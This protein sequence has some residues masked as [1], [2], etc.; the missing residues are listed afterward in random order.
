MLEINS[1]DASVECWRKSWRNTTQQ[2]RCRFHPLSTAFYTY[3]IV[4][5]APCICPHAPQVDGTVTLPIVANVSLL[6][7]KPIRPR[8]RVLLLQLH[9][10]FA[11]K[12]MCLKCQEAESCLA[13]RLTHQGKQTHT[14]EDTINREECEL[15]QLG[16]HHLVWYNQDTREAGH[17]TTTDLSVW[18]AYWDTL[19]R[20]PTPICPP[21]RP[22]PP[23]PGTGGGLPSFSDESAQSPVRGQW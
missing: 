15:T 14:A 10:R 7:C 4:P 12:L 17:G 19:Y 13:I 16:H 18:A 2:V 6:K 23:E 20:R 5:H 11:G 21:H 3:T 8:Q 22:P 9:S 1:D